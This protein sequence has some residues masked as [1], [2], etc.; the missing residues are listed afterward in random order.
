MFHNVGT[1][2]LPLLYNNYDRNVRLNLTLI[3]PGAI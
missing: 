3:N 2:G 1:S